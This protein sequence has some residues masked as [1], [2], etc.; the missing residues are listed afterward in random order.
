MNRPE[1][2]VQQLKAQLQHTS[3][4]T[5]ISEMLP[6]NWLA[7]SLAN[8]ANAV[9]FCLIINVHAYSIPDNF[10]RKLLAQ[11]L[12]VKYVTMYFFI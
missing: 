6:I 4:R 9:H 1:L 8:Y 10:S 7:I 2:L 11:F 5:K 12:K 3:K